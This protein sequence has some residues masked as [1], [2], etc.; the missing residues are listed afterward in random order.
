M[1]PTLAT[2]TGSRRAAAPAPAD[3][4]PAPTVADASV[5]DDGAHD[6][7]AAAFTALQ[8]AMTG[9]AGGERG[10]QSDG[11]GIGTLG[12]TIPVEYQQCAQRHHAAP[13]PP[14]ARA[15]MR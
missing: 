11:D 4:L 9:G 5:V 14:P 12:D 6:E 15:S 13:R 7:F 10:Q 8:D 2:G 1:R 3:N